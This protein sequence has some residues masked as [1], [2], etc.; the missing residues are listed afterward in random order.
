MQSISDVNREIADIRHVYASL[1]AGS[2]AHQ[3][4][5]QRGAAVIVGIAVAGRPGD[6]VVERRR[7][8]PSAGRR[9]TATSPPSPGSRAAQLTR[10]TRCCAW[11]R[12]RCRPARN[13]DGRCGR[14][15]VAAAAGLRTADQHIRPALATITIRGETVTLGQETYVKYREDSDA[16]VREQVFKAFLARLQVVPAH[17]R[18]DLRRAPARRRVRRPRTQVRRLAAV[19]AGPGQHARYRLPYPGGR[20]QRRPARCRRYLKLRG[21]LL[22][23]QGQ[24]YSDIYAELVKAPRTYTLGEAEAITLKAWRRWATTTSN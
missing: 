17:D 8:R 11:P 18:R 12:T 20:G 7:S 1:K 22:G 5:R 10:C 16:A 23:I 6:R 4:H 24:K 21:R 2:K 13:P 3:V 15:A 19:E 14:S 9:S